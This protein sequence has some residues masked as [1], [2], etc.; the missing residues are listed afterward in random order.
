MD[1]K[2]KVTIYFVGGLGNNL[3]QIS[4]GQYLEESGIKVRFDLSI[5]RKF[6]YSKFDYFQLTNYLKRRI[7]RYSR[8]FPAPN[9][10][11]PR[12][13]RLIRFKAKNEFFFDFSSLGLLITSNSVPNSLIGYWQRLLYTEILATNFETIKKINKVKLSL[14]FL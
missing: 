3:F 2:K 11:Y 13:A 12:L 5:N 9:G 10:R 14:F 4:L 8:Y 7:I 1:C 6:D